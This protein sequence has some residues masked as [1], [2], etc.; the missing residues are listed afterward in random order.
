[1]LVPA[2]RGF[3]HS[4]LA[5]VVLHKNLSHAVGLLRGRGE[6]GR[7]GERRRPEGPHP[8]SAW[9]RVGPVLHGAASRAR[10]C[11]QREHRLAP[12][13]APLP[14]CCSRVVRCECRF[15][16]VRR[17]RA[18]RTPQPRGELHPPRLLRPLWRG[19][20]P[21][22]RGAPACCPRSSAQPRILRSRAGVGHAPSDATLAVIPP[23]PRRSASH[24]EKVTTA[25]KRKDNAARFLGVA[26]T[27]GAAFFLASNYEELLDK[28]N[29]TFEV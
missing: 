17:G 18:G 3:A 6:R 12:L 5:R 8:C 13:R 29:G 10:P 1:M 7:E 24:I 22:S 11:V 4:P 27:G 25:Q 26:V 20:R 14:P 28:W 9:P 21:D 2:P 15:L 19:P 23:S 16:A